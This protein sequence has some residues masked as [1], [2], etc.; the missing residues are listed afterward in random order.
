MI[1]FTT[2][3][4]L[5]WQPFMGFALALSLV[6]CV[7]SA[8][9]PAT[10]DIPA[11]T[12]L[13]T[14]HINFEDGRPR[15]REIFCGVLEDH[16]Q[17]LPDY[18]NCEEALARVDEEP[19]GDTE[20]V[21]LGPSQGDFLV[22]LVPGL[23]WQCVRNWLDNDHS[24]T[25][26]LYELGYDARLFEV[27]GLSSTQSNASQLR[28][29]ISALPP[30]DSERP[31]ILIGYS[32]GITD[33][34]EAIN[35]YPELRVRVAA[36]VSVAG[37]VG[38]SPLVEEMQQSHLNLLS[39]IPGSG[40]ETGDEGAIESLQPETRRNW[41]ADNDLPKNIPY[42]S[43]VAYPQPEQLSFGLKHSYK[44]LAALDARND[45]NLIF[46]DQLI[47]GATLLAF[48]NA[49][50]WAMSI[51]VARQKALNR[52]TFASKNAYPREAL[53]E[54]ILRYIEEDLARRATQATQLPTTPG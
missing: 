50:H 23:A 48:V 27:D 32:K 1:R 52:S 8:T 12:L 11:M 14:K 37:A 30:G 19:P 2:G 17:S 15:F 16:G 3:K 44:K 13:A 10:S 28:D 38:G 29:L 31:L 5:G 25:R 6:S 35:R 33:V 42:Y 24:G 49:D 43:V 47:P 53:L 39:H 18:R 21:E 45:G 26:H 36:V 4:A 7:S 9:S 22:G 51:P 20:V 46:Y 40:C 54:A 34:L 41:L